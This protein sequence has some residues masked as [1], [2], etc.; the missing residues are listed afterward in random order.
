M[1]AK[2]IVIKGNRLNEIRILYHILCIWYFYVQLVD[3]YSNHFKDH[4]SS[5]DH[6]CKIISVFNMC[7]KSWNTHSSGD[8]WGVTSS[9]LTNR[10]WVL[11]IRVFI[12]R[13]NKNNKTF[14]I[15]CYNY[16]A[17]FMSVYERTKL[18]WHITYRVNIKGLSRHNGRYYV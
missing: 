12:K 13:P 2:R 6:Q 3:K 5:G 17:M 1:N 10:K 11:F 4:L 14:R 8:W 18:N 7:L 15:H 9:Q 16:H